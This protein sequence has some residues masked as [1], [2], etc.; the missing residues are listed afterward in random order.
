MPSSLRSSPKYADK[1]PE[2]G[3]GGEER[4]LQI[5]EVGASIVW[6]DPC[7]TLNVT[8][9]YR[10]TPPCDQSNAIYVDADCNP[11][12][13]V[14]GQE[15]LIN[16]VGTTAPPPPGQNT[17]PDLNPLVDP[18]LFAF[19]SPAGDKK[20]HLQWDNASELR[21]DPITG[22][23]LFEGYRVWRVDNWQ[24]P[25]GSIGPSPEEWMKIAEFREHPEDSKSEGARNLR[26]IKDRD[27]LPIGQTEDE[28]PKDIYPIGYYSYMDS[29]GIL[30]GKLYFYSVTAFGVTVRRNTV[31]GRDEVVELGGQPAAVEA[32]AVIPRWGATPGCDNI[33]VVPNPY[34]G[35]ADWDLIPSDSDP[36]GSK[37]AFNNLPPTRCTIR[38]Y[39]LAGDLIVESTHDGR[40]GDGTYLWNLITRNGQ[41]VTSGIYLYSAEYGDYQTEDGVDVAGEICRGRFVIIR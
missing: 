10:S 28:I 33:K 4:C 13:G 30:N 35:G 2:T 39:T 38:I 12:T 32:E 16:W 40:S 26:E 25:E 17:D 29:L 24:R 22:E 34:R 31:T 21:K 5:L 14:D 37:I 7:D 27:M 3:I 6:D 20:I 41:N 9:E 36:T 19:V 8:Q 1:N 23:E 18:N 15:A 11:C